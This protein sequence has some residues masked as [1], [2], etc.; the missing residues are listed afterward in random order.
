MITG[1]GNW[2]Y[3][4][5]NFTDEVISVTDSVPH[6]WV[7]TSG[8]WSPVWAWPHVSAGHCLCSS[9]ETLATMS[10]RRGHV[11]R[12]PIT[13]QGHAG[14]GR[15]IWP[16]VY[17]GGSHWEGCSSQTGPD[18]QA[19]AAPPSL[20]NWITSQE[21]RWCFNEHKKPA[22]RDKSENGGEFEFKIS[23]LGKSVLYCICGFHFE[24]I[25]D[26]RKFYEWS[27]SVLCCS[28]QSRDL[29]YYPR[30]LTIF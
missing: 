17:T 21:R 14:V 28:Q 12:L 6:D 22:S 27:G 10:H 5:Q 20:G 24:S 4:E 26:K 7:L 8:Q 18:T 30:C 13:D 2:F 19:R 15:V 23:K 3:P 11:T 1:L 29:A 25:R 9:P 16:H